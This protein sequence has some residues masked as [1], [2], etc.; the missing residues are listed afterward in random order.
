MMTSCPL[1]FNQKN[2]FHH[3]AWEVEME[4][5]FWGREWWGKSFIA[6][7]ISLDTTKGGR[8]SQTLWFVVIGHCKEGPHTHNCTQHHTHK[9]WWYCTHHAAAPT[10]PI[11]PPS[12]A[13]MAPWHRIANCCL[14]QYYG[15]RMA[16]QV[17]IYSWN[18]TP[19]KQI[20]YWM[21]LNTMV[22]EGARGDSFIHITSSSS[23]TALSSRFIQQLWR[24]SEELH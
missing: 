4:G 1:L 17:G 5:I 12:H 6:T 11:T 22:V 8:S 23:A 24:K 18:N 19:R 21:G 13:A 16:E 2:P 14:W 15:C 3:K 10:A 20:A 7:S 9:S